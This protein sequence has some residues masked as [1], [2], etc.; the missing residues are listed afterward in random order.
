MAIAFDAATDGGLVN[1][2]TSLPWNHVVVAAGSIVVGVFGDNVATDATG[3]KITGV[4]SDIG[5][6]FTEIDRKAVT[7]DRWVYL[8]L[9]TVA[10]VGT[11]AITVN[12]S[13]SIAIA[14]QSVSY[15]GT[16]QSGQPDNSATNNGSGVSAT[17]TLTPVANNCWLPMVVKVSAGT[18]SPAGS[19]SERVEA[20]GMAM[21]DNNAAVTPPGS[22]TLTVTISG[23]GS[24]WATV[25][26]S[27]APTAGQRF[28]LTPS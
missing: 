21:Y 5:G 16:K 27:L 23:G 2:G 11:H 8:F 19:E 28:F 10:V 7:A 18:L 26:A 14:G 22:T 25:I 13:S 15:S 1:P 3:N 4:T 24:A 6:A 20:N 12:A 17:G 9:L